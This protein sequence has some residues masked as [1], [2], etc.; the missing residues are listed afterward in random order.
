MQQPYNSLLS[1]LI[2]QTQPWHHSKTPTL[3]V[4]L[5]YM[6]TAHNLWPS[7]YLVTGMCNAINDLCC[8]ILIVYKTW[9]EGAWTHHLGQFALCPQELS[10]RDEWWRKGLTLKL[11]TR[12]EKTECKKSLNLKESSNSQIFTVSDVQVAFIVWKWYHFISFNVYF[13]LL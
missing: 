3:W 8:Y 10:K 12:E 5:T 4:E 13:R 6:C 7:E 1:W 11:F 9:G 2:Q